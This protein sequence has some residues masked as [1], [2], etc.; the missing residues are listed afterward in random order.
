MGYEHGGIKHP[1]SGT[2]TPNQ[3][4]KEMDKIH[5]QSVREGVKSFI[6]GKTTAGRMFRLFALLAAYYAEQ[7]RSL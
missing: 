7:I 1:D 2:Q 6:L 5:E 3:L 4:A